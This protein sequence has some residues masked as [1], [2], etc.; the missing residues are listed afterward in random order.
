MEIAKYFEK[1]SKKRDSSNNSS[2][3]EASKKLPE[4]SID[5]SAVSDVS[6]NNY[7]PFTEELKSPTCVSISMNCLRNLEKQVDQIFKVL[8]KIE[9]RQIKV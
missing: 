6:A 9:D 5:N 1:I 8:K 7:D 3:E 4:G 2:D